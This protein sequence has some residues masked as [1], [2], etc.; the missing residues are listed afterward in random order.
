MRTRS[1][2]GDG[3]AA[4]WMKRL[5]LRANGD[6]LWAEVAWTPKAAEAIKN[7]E[8]QIHLARRS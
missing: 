2:P 6:E 3:A 1:C 5:E 7:R 8:Y 4:G